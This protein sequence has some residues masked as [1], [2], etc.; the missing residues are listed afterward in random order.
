MRL[1]VAG[2]PGFGLGTGSRTRLLEELEGLER[3]LLVTLF[4][5]L[6]RR[7]PECAAAV[8]AK[9]R[10]DWEGSLGRSWDVPE[11]EGWEMN[12]SEEPG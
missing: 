10:E 2:I 12:T 5:S 1:D 6:R 11:A 7:L 3:K 8:P 9:A 4:R